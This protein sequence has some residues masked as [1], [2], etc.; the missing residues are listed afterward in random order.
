MPRWIRSTQAALENC[1]RFGDR[2]RLLSFESLLEDTRGTIAGIA[3]WL[4]IDWHDVLTR[5]SFQN[6]DIRANSSWKVDRAG[7]LEEPLQRARELGA[8]DLA[9]IEKSSLDLYEQVLRS[10]D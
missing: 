4:G 2:V 9:S 5:P 7:V 8:E 10:I 6:F 3:D 1:R